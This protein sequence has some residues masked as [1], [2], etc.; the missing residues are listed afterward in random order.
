MEAFVLL[1]QFHSEIRRATGQLKVSEA[2]SQLITFTSDDQ[3]IH[4][5]PSPYEKSRDGNQL[6]F[7]YCLD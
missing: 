5:V 7:I 6:S 1:F 4:H 2:D 3:L